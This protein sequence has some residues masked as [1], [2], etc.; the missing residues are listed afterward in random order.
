MCENTHSKV[1]EMCD[2]IDKGLKEYEASAA[3]VLAS[4]E[5]SV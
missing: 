2:E 1:R 5:F 4:T 3:V